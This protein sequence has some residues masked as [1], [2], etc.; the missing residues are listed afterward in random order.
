MQQPPTSFLEWT[1]KFAT[2]EACLAELA[3]RKWPGGFICPRCGHD[4]AHVLRRRDTR[5]CLA[6]RHQ[7]SPTA[8]TVFEHTKLPLAKWF[9]AIYLTAADKG[10]VSALRLSRMVGVSWPTAQSM[11][12]KLRRAMGDRDRAYWLTGLV[13]ADDALVGG[14]RPGKRGRGAG[15]K[16]PVLFAVERR[17]ERAGFLAAQVVGRVTHEQV[18]AFSRRLGEGLTIRSDAFSGLTVLARDHAHQPRPTP[19]E[20]ADQWLPLVHLVISNF[21]RFLIGTFHGVSRTRLQEY[22]DEFVF[23]FNRRFWE[24][25]LPARLVE[26]AVTHV[27]VPLRLKHV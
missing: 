10:G 20:K 9:A 24:D 2:E 4:R 21:K 18:A 15:G 5:Q 17:G 11:L 26:A 6:C 25:Q 19:P 8:G 13:E 12:R 23:R 14:K 27:P 22:L 7:S 16:Q 3:R 1:A